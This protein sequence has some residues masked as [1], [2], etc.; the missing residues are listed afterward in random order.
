MLC[1]DQWSIE[2][3]DMGVKREW[4]SEYNDLSPGIPWKTGL[5]ANLSLLHRGHGFMSKLGRAMIRRHLFCGIINMFRSS[6]I[7]HQ[8]YHQIGA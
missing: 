3:G 7:M 6:V 1:F 2:K 8:G 5:G 4:F